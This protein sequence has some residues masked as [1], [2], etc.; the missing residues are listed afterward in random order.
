MFDYLGQL[1]FLAD[2]NTM[3]KFLPQC[4]KPDYTD[5]FLIIDCTELFIEKPSQIV[6]Q[7]ATWSDYIGHNAGKALLGLSPIILPV[8]VSDVY[9][10]SISDEE[11]LVQSGILALSHKGDRWMDDKGFIIQHILDNYGVSIDTPEKLAG[12][13]QFNEQED[14]HNRRNCQV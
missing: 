5:A 7:S 2:H 4:F 9:L 13:K 14:I 12:K 10:G 1:N 8:F 11:I 6:Q 3:K